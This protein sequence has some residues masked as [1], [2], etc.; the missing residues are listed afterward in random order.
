[1]KRFL[2]AVIAF[3][4]FQL[5][6]LVVV[7]GVFYGTPRA[8]HP[9]GWGVD[10]QRL[11]QETPGPRLILAGDSG[12]AFGFLSPELEQALPPY[13]PINAGLWA[14]L[15]PHVILEEVAPEVRAGDVV[16][17]SLAYEHFVSSKLHHLI[18]YYTVQRPEVFL[19]LDSPT[20][21]FLCDNAFFIFHEA[22]V[23]SRK[24]LWR[25]KLDTYYPP[26]ARDS[27]N[28]YGDIVD[29]WDMER[30]AGSNYTNPPFRF[31]TGGRAA[32][33]VDELNDFARRC[34]ARGARV[35]Y[36]YPPLTPESYEGQR[37]RFDAF[38]A[39]LRESLEF[40]VLNHPGDL[41]VPEEHLYDN[42]YH[43][44]K[45]GAETRTQALIDDLRPYLQ[46][47]GTKP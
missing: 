23:R 31:K 25:S 7:V 36:Q 9:M 18:V 47:D 46:N 2:K 14:F 33:V 40:P 38:D 6:L 21:L 11:L 35:F 30:P 13:H 41:L 16:V 37:A 20:A 10:K 22:T 1:M 15:G 43:T 5:V 4:A 12:T 3:S 39:Y 17:V 42:L 24:L 45:P 29:H 19:H 32:R 8:D 26:Y 27:I 34:E 44:M 28:E